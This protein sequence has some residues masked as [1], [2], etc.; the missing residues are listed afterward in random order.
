MNRKF[1]PFRIYGGIEISIDGED[2]LVFGLQDS[3]LETTRWRYPDLRAFVRERHG[4][5]VLAH[6]FR[7]HARID[8][9]LVSC[10]PDAIELHSTNTPVTY[11]AVIREIAAA[12]RL[13]MLSNSDAHTAGAI[14]RHFNLIEVETGDEREIVERLREGDF[15][16]VVKH[17]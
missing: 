7:Y 3:V 10:T 4:L 12:L 14:G 9:D 15:A 6:P 1:A 5:L 13:P 8:L 2:L 17:E 16:P 11:A